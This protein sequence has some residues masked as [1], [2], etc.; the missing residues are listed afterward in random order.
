VRLFSFLT[1]TTVAVI[2]TCVA[3]IATGMAWYS[4]VGLG[5]SVW[6]LAQVLYVVLIGISARQV[7]QEAIPSVRGQKWLSMRNGDSPAKKLSDTDQA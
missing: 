6:V 2:A 3:A 5:L 7:K 4:V 1:G